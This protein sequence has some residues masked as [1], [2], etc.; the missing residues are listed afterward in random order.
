MCTP[1]VGGQPKGERARGWYKLYRS[2]DLLS[3][4]TLHCHYGCEETHAAVAI[5]TNSVADA[6]LLLLVLLVLLLLLLLLQPLRLPLPLPLLCGL[7]G[8]I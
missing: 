4:E 3:E 5:A 2:I 8:C 7:L 1:H 6:L